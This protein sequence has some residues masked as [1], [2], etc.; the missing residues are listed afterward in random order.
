ME[1][2]FGVGI[3]VTG[4]CNQGDRKYME[5]M[6]SVVYQQTQNEGDLAYAFFGIFDGHGGAEAALFAK[7]YLM[8]R[9]V[10]NKLFWSDDDKDILKAIR[11]GFIQTHLSM[12]K[13]L[14]NWPKTASGHHSTAGTTASILFVKKGKAYVGHVGD[15]GIVMGYEEKDGKEWKAMSLTREHKPESKLEQERIYKSGGKVVLKAG[16]PRVVWNRPRRGHQGPVRRSTP[17]D[18]IPFLS[19]AM[20]V[21]PSKKLVDEALRRWSAIG[22]RADN[23]SALTLMLDPARTVQ[24]ELEEVNPHLRGGRVE[25]HLGTPPPVHLTEIRTSI[26][27]SSAVELNTTSVLAN[28]ATEIGDTPTTVTSESTYDEEH[29]LAWI[30][31]MQQ[32]DEVSDEEDE[33]DGSDKG[34]ADMTLLT[35]SVSKENPSEDGD[36]GHVDKNMFVDISDPEAMVEG[37]ESACPQPS[38]SSEYVDPSSVSSEF[39]DMPLDSL[40]VC[41][42][43]KFIKTYY[44]QRQMRKVGETSRGIKRSERQRLKTRIG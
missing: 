17:I 31:R 9:I 42:I 27:P 5:D 15:S 44:T 8:E 38:T 12:W 6:F 41:S 11:D 14:D 23:T 1:S 28:Y 4:H 2:S 21:N 30:N 33:E 39:T 29:F 35:Q 3:R 37:G 26:S 19:M 22:C 36:K 10:T 13:N 16:V 18:E 40:T 32:D 25:N 20:W 7:N 43:K 24:V 34:D